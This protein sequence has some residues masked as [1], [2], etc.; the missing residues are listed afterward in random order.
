MVGD[1]T[2]AG[3]CCGAGGVKLGMEFTNVPES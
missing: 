2:N 3:E 1:D